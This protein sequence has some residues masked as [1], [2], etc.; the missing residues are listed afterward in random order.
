MLHAIRT[1]LGFVCGARDARANTEEQGAAGDAGSS[2]TKRLKTGHFMSQADVASHQ[3][4]HPRV[5]AAVETFARNH[6]HAAAFFNAFHQYRGAAPLFLQASE[7]QYLL[8]THCGM[9]PAKSAAA[10]QQ[11][12]ADLLKAAGV[13]RDP[14]SGPDVS[15]DTL[16]PDELFM[17]ERQW[18]LLHYHE[19]LI[20]W[21]ERKGTPASIGW[22]NM[23]F[24]AHHHGQGKTHF[25][26]LAASPRLEDV[27]RLQNHHA[28]S[29]KN[30]QRFRNQI[31]KLLCVINL[32]VSMTQLLPSSTSGTSGDAE[33]ARLLWLSF[34]NIMQ[35]L[36]MPLDRRRQ[37]LRPDLVI[38]MIYGEFG[39]QAGSVGFQI[40]VDRAE[41]LAEHANTFQYD[42]PRSSPPKPGITG[43]QVEWRR[44]GL[45]ELKAVHAVWKSVRTALA[46]TGV[47]LL[48]TEVLR[49]T[50]SYRDA[51]TTG[52]TLAEELGFSLECIQ[53]PI[54]NAVHMGATCCE[55]GRVPCILC[56]EVQA[57]C[58]PSAA[59]LSPQRTA[60]PASSPT[61]LVN[62]QMRGATTAPEA[63]LTSSDCSFARFVQLLHWLTCGVPLLIR[64]ALRAALWQ[65]AQ[66]LADDGRS[67]SQLCAA[68]MRQRFTAQDSALV[69][70]LLNDKRRVDSIVCDK[71]DPAE[72]RRLLLQAIL[73][74][75]IQLSAVQDVSSAIFKASIYTTCAEVDKDFQSPTKESWARMTFEPIRVQPMIPPYMLPKYETSM[76]RPRAILCHALREVPE[77]IGE[78]AAAEMA[79]R[80]ETAELIMKSIASSSNRT[81]G[82]VF[83]F[84]TSSPHASSAFK[85]PSHKYIPGAKV[86]L[87]L[88]LDEETRRLLQKLPWAKLLAPAEV[89][90]QLQCL[91]EAACGI[92]HPNSAGPDLIFLSGR[93]GERVAAAFQIK[94]RTRADIT[95]PVLQG[96][97]K[98][99]GTHA[100]A[101]REAMR[102][103]AVYLIYLIVGSHSLQLSSSLRA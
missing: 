27:E 84:M 83:S 99:T 75:P 58:Q 52:R 56:S 16:V 73:G 100:S 77:L 20:D 9:E 81:L 69:T 12:R 47:W 26:R 25:G 34:C 91:W 79:V 92:P 98:R 30:L 23:H 64:E 59:A 90:L 82:S 49:K 41:A 60:Q 51:H 76:G 5:T 11:L 87:K 37:F 43:E 96:E 28:G 3:P 2:P 32:E 71:L 17:V 18:Q 78:G 33:L 102:V 42:G 53:K 36:E 95:G 55:G 14:W 44:Q 31:S 15:T 93:E 88:V 72:K 40:H 10:A 50:C 1:L 101:W 39:F 38:E 61:T 57:P 8:Q 35:R 74:I 85:S 89:G 97:I 7:L 103:R 48:L 45:G 66:Q 21:E 22:R 13:T 65:Q 68:A 24:S 19:N 63:S 4:T 29:S 67:W 54:P 94:Y 46:L 6:P 62:Q 86:Q 80:L 70:H